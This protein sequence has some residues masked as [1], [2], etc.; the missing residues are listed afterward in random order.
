MNSIDG[1]ANTIRNQ[2]YIVACFMCF[3]FSKI[4]FFLLNKF[5]RVFAREK[6]KRERKC[7]MQ[8]AMPVIKPICEKLTSKPFQQIILIENLK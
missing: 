8:C 6:Q 3:N 4:V 5:L 1:F 7:D 2:L